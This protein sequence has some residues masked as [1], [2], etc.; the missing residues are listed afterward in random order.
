[1]GDAGQIDTGLSL[2]RVHS[3]LNEKSTLSGNSSWEGICPPVNKMECAQGKIFPT[4]ISVYWFWQA[5]KVAY[6]HTKQPWGSFVDLNVCTLLI[7]SFNLHLLSVALASCALH[8]SQVSVGWANAANLDALLFSFNKSP[9]SEVK[10]AEYFPQ[11]VF[12]ASDNSHLP[13]LLWKH[14]MEKWELWLCS[15]S[16]DI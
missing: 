10:R 9:P 4:I 6:I 12:E 3:C 7:P 1:M 11:L 16:Q 5:G 15:N 2:V 14:S 8:K 13:F